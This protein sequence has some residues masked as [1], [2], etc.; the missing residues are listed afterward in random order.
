MYTHPIIPQI[1]SLS[2]F[3]YNWSC[4]ASIFI[5]ILIFVFS[6]LCF[7]IYLFI[8]FICI[9]LCPCAGPIFCYLQHGWAQDDIVVLTTRGDIVGSYTP[10][11]PLP[12]DDEHVSVADQDGRAV[13]GNK[14]PPSPQVGCLLQLYNF[15][16]ATFVI[17]YIYALLNNQSLTD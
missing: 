12:G 1:V 9:N 3:E 2:V 11:E 14:L 15:T 8:Y 10:G 13:E 4:I 16:L 5:S 17:S 6:Y 7:F